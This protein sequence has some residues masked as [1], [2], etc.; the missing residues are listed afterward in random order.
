MSDHYDELLEQVIRRVDSSGSL[1]KAEIA[2]LSFWK[3]LNANTRWASALLVRPD[4]E[5]HAVTAR[6]VAAARDRSVPTPDAASA[7][8]ELLAVL[9]GFKARGPLAS[10]VLLAAAPDRMA[11]Y[12]RR[13]RAG[14]ARIDCPLV[15]TS[16]V[17][18]RYITLVETLADQVNAR[19]YQWTARDV[20]KAL[21]WLGG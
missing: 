1:G 20:D 8:L 3:R 12:D 19:G 7:A 14:L 18:V 10:A 6:V 13:A 2:A 9:P 16:R 11:V 21:Y 4:A 17:Y 15:G 5:V